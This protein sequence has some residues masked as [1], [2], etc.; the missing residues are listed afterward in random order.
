MRSF[1][2]DVQVILIGE[3]IFAGGVP[4]APDHGSPAREDKHDAVPMA[5]SASVGED[6]T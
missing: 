5:G 4:A 3:Q 1:A 6:G 2:A